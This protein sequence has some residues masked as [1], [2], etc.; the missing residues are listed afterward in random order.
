VQY[1]GL[2]TAKG[3]LWPYSYFTYGLIVTNIVKWVVVSCWIVWISVCKFIL[4]VFI[5]HMLFFSLTY[6]SNKLDLVIYYFIK[7]EIV[8]CR[9]K[10][11]DKLLWI[12]MRSRWEVF[13]L[14]HLSDQQRLI[15]LLLFLTDVFYSKLCVL[16]HLLAV[17]WLNG[18]LF[19][20]YYYCYY[21]YNY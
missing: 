2:G 16:Y 10:H 11:F 14:L 18:I 20:A 13:S 5:L 9:L 17:M 3:G 7:R 21:Y 19:C 1:R 6:C 4:L 15:F 8:C 12:V